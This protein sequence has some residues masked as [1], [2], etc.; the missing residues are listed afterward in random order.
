[1][2]GREMTLNSSNEEVFLCE[3][4]EAL[5]QVAQRRCGCP[6]QEGVPGVGTRWS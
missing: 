1:M 2:H 5:E 4:G 3:G 6:T